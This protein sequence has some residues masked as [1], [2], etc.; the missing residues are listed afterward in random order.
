MDNVKFMVI[1]TIH[2]LS[3]MLVGMVADADRLFLCVRSKSDLK[4]PLE[5]KHGKT[6]EGFSFLFSFMP[7]ASP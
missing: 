3:H 2:K 7:E 6:P 5:S 4:K 1:V